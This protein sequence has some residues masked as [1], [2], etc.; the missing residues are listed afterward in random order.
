[1]VL[2]QKVAAFSGSAA[3]N[4]RFAAG[5]FIFALAGCAGMVPQTSA[6]LEGLPEGLPQ[7]VE[8][9]EVPFFPQA[10]YQCG[11]AALATLLVSSGVSTTPEALVPQVYLPA[12]KGSLQVEMLA[13]ARRHGLVS[14]QLAP[15]AL[16]VMRELAAGTP[17]VV[18]QNL[19]I[20]EGWHY[21]VAV[22]YDYK[23]GMM[24][25]RSGTTEREEMPFAVHEMVWKRSGYWAMVAVPPERIPVTADEARWLG[26]LVAFERLNEP[27]KNRLAYAAFLERWPGNVNAAI[28]LANAHHALGELPQAEK[29]LRGALARSPD[30]AIVLNNLAQ[31]LSDQGRDAEALPLA[32]RAVATGGQHAAAVRETR[33]AILKKLGKN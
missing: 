15:S 1:V 8:L 28:G 7:Q 13:A 20:S 29:V 3:R 14:Y 17:V 23:L 18:L 27:R 16:D 24:I 19:G 9:K 2:L 31:T 10:E 6:L 12:R 32:E 30:S 11:P 4:A 22:G 25:L 33:D 26:S 21:A 5:V